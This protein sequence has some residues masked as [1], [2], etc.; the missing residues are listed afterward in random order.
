[1]A[2]QQVIVEFIS[3]TSQLTPAV[4]KLTALGAI[5]EKSAAIFKATNDQIK[6]RN[7]LLQTTV[8]SSKEVSSE[9]SEQQVIYNK[10]SASVKTLSGASKDA[11]QNLLKMSQADLAKTFQGGANSV[12]NYINSLQEGT[13]ETDRATKST[14]TLRAQLREV[15]NELARLTLAGETEGQEFT[16]LATKA[17]K[18][19]NAMLDTQQTVANLGSDVPLVRVFTGSIEGI[20]GAFTAAT[21]A[22]A[23]F[24]DDNKDLQEVLV[25]VNGVMAINA[26][27]SQALNFVRDEALISTI[28]VIALQ[29]VE[30]AQLAIN[31]GL[32]SESIIVR[33]AATV[34]QYALNLAM[35][36]NPIGLVVI[37]VAA[38][39]TAIALYT[40]SATKAAKAQAQLNAVLAETGHILDAGIAGVENANKK[41]ISGLEERNARE[42]EIQAQDLR[43]LQANNAQ[44]LTAI[45]ELNAKITA[46][47]A[48][49]NKDTQELVKQAKDQVEKLETDSQAAQADIVAKGN[50]L[51]KQL[52]VESLQDQADNIQA[53]LS[54]ATKNSNQEFALE[55]QLA[56]AKSAIDIQAAGDDAAKVL[57]IRSA[58]ARELKDIDIAQAAVAQDAIAAAQESQLIKAQNQ[59]RAINDRVSQEEI[60]I[61]KKQILEIADFQAKQEG[62][63]NQRRQQIRD[64]ANQKALELQRNFNM[65]SAVEAL[66]DQESLNNKLL[67]QVNI[68]DKEKLDLQ[69]QNIILAASEEIEQNRGKI[70]KI[71]EIEAKRDLD[72]KSA[73]LQSIQETLDREV[74]LIQAQN[75]PEIDALQKSL[76]QQEKLRDLEGNVEQQ[77]LQRRLGIQKLNNA[78]LFALIDQVTERQLDADKK[79][80]DSLQNQLDQG[81]I[82]NKDYEVKYAQLKDDE[83]KITQTAEQ[84]KQK[85]I[86]DGIAK[87]KQLFQQGVEQAAQIAQ[88]GVSLLSQLYSNMNDSQQ[89]AIDAQRQRIQDLS[90]SGAISAK[91]ASDRNKQLDKEQ[92]K[93][94][95]DQAVRDKQ[96]AIFNASINL[97]TAVLKAYS[98]TGPIAGAVFAGIIGVLGAAEIAAIAAKPIP[99]LAKGKKGNYQ[100]F[101]LT[102]E[103]GPEIIRRGGRDQ[104]VDSPTITWLGASDKVYNPKETAAMI[105][106]RV[107]NNFYPGS[108]SADSGRKDFDYD[109]FGRLM[110]E[111][112]PQTGIGFDE[113]GLYQWTQTKNSFTKYLNKRR[114]WL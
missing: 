57:A 105:E 56:V 59:S 49:T 51:K 52:L 45:A 12:D 14:T 33:G 27:I 82:S 38:F 86:E 41:I 9:V 3:D 1:M 63:T 35:S 65:Q 99:A 72:I 93:L 106:A 55:R 47:Q 26:G 78:Q 44:R 101:A 104:L 77:Q 76:D 74:S 83:I 111:N 110:R 13:I 97:A 114:R 48:S 98:S 18:L 79:K 42:S 37:A 19:K 89:Q 5:D 22:A 96:L 36:L 17:G 95:H 25:K 54:L 70:A 94:Q 53:R 50:E 10:L 6:Q 67:D 15:T 58:L 61:Q 39:I 103:A 21:G 100:G 108:A 87:Q 20:T 68:G 8:E 64:E 84:K 40:S 46:N 60:D 107:P 90:D 4:D 112:I 11:V 75:D 24:G 85:I 30:A 73:R 7:S 69:I 2:D 43:A 109:R 102:G 81:L 66:Q 92:R 113:H 91:E 31:N 28:K 16:D 88:A 29:K 62:L 71:K 23:L 32:Q 80:E 34:A